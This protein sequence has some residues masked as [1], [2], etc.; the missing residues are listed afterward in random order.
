M[1]E[2]EPGGTVVTPAAAPAAAPEGAGTVVTSS[3]NNAPGPGGEPPPDPTSPPGDGAPNTPDDPK[4]QGD[5]DGG[6]TPPNDGEPATA[7]PDEYTEFSVGEG[8]Q[9][10]DEGMSRFKEFAKTQGMSQEAAQTTMDYITGEMPRFVQDVQQRQLDAYMQMSM[11]WKKAYETDPNI[12]G[13]KM[14]ETETEAKRALNYLNDPDLVAILDV[15]NPETNPKGMALGN[16]RSIINMLAKFGA[17]IREDGHEGG[18]DNL[19]GG[20]EQSTS[21]RW[22][23]AT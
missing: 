15:Y 21:E 4:G 19:G 3:T 20:R 6:D 12:G 23:G 14:R 18:D 9:V 16:H 2:V 7:A 13:T 22:Y 10:D 5:P 11:D 17:A 8:N 1:S